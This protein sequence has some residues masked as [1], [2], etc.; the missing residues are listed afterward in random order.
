VKG[1]GGN[2]PSLARARLRHAADDAALVE[3]LKEGIPGTEMDGAWQLNDRE[4]G[5]VAAYVRSLGQT[6]EA[7]LPGDAGKGKALFGK[8]DCA[9]CHVVQGQGGSLG[10]DLTEVGAR[11]GVAYLRRLLREPGKDHPLDAAGFVAFLVV[12]VATQD[13]RVVRGLRINEDTF[14]IQLRDADNRLHSF[15]K[16]ALAELKREWNGSLMPSYAEAI[17]AADL[18]DLIAYLASLR[19]QRPR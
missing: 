12:Q 5:Q 9:R 13:G 3:V 11:R 6:E 15:P 14:T 2:G 4:I 19:G 8:S 17:P 7:A 1:A 10:P 16:R 18:D